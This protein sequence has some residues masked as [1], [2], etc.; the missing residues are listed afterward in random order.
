MKAT[1]LASFFGLMSRL[2]IR[3]D[4]DHL[5][6]FSFKVFFGVEGVEDDLKRRGTFL[7]VYVTD[8]SLA[9]D[10]FIDAAKENLNY[11]AI[12]KYPNPY[13][14]DDNELMYIIRITNEEDEW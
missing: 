10:Y 9:Q 11:P 12:Y 1:K 3:F 13:T 4:V 2:E 14:E 5:D 8:N 6:G 7:S